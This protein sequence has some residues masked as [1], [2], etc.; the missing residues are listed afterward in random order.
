MAEHTVHMDS[1]LSSILSVKKVSVLAFPRR[2]E[3]LPDFR[4]KG[5][6]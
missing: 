6:F 4:P 2:K 5:A 3:L 1:F